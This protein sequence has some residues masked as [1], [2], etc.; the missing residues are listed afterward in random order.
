MYNN[1]FEVDRM[2]LCILQQARL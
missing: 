2:L 1:H